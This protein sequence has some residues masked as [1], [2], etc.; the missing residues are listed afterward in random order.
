MH[1]V[2]CLVYTC[3]LACC[4]WCVCEWFICVCGVFVSVCVL[5]GL[6]V[7]CVVCACVCEEKERER[8]RW[9]CAPSLKAVDGVRFVLR[10]CQALHNCRRLTVRTT[11]DMYP[12]CRLI[13]FF[14]FFYFFLHC[15]WL[16]PVEHC[17]ALPGTLVFHLIWKTS[18]LKI[19]LDS[20]TF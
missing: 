15:T 4:V 20:I 3:V 11:H 14:I 5:C 6:Y 9:L 17:F 1:V 16:F 2:Y 19:R 10:G 18:V 13:S 12:A 8:E 7:L